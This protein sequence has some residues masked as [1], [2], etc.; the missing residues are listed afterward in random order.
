ME[1]TEV[2]FA[3]YCHFGH[4]RRFFLHDCHLVGWLETPKEGRRNKGIGG[5]LAPHILADQLTL[6][7]PGGA[8]Y[9]PHIST[10]TPG[11]SDLPTALLL[12]NVWN[13]LLT[14]NLFYSLSGYQLQTWL[15]LLDIIPWKKSTLFLEKLYR[16]TKT[17]EILSWP[18]WF[19]H[20]TWTSELVYCTDPY[21]IQLQR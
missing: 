10:G 16:L 15:Q 1:E 7:Q 20:C 4:R 9:A 18:E 12:K 8:D 2:T 13:L 21:Q 19:I 14:F 5:L 11:F 6:S 3:F 17:S